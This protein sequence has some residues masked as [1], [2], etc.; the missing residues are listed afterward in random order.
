MV[1][2]KIT[3]MKLVVNDGN[4]LTPM[5]T[6]YVID[7]LY[8]AEPEDNYEQFY[9]DCVKQFSDVVNSYATSSRREMFTKIR[10]IEYV[11]HPYTWEDFI[12]APDRTIISL[13]ENAVAPNELLSIT[14]TK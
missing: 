6:N 10:L 11:L 14:L 7:N 2:R 8:R 13:V 9:Q 5:M 12:K 3:L 1:K 4:Q